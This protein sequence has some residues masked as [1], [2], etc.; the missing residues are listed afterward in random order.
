VLAKILSKYFFG[1]DKWSLQNKMS[2]SDYFF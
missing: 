2:L 1:S